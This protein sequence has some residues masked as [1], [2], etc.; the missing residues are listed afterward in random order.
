VLHVTCKHIGFVV[1]YK[2]QSTCTPRWL[3]C[4]VELCFVIT[5]WKYSIHR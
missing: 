1:P 2:F 4:V 3:S 5:W